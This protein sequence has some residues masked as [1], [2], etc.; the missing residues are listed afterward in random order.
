MKQIKRWN[1]SK[2][3]SLENSKIDSF[4]RDVLKVCEKHKMIVL[5]ILFINV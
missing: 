3:Q 5:L 4:I 1:L 2:K